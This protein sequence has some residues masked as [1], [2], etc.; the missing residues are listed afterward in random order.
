MPSQ[1]SSDEFYSESTRAALA[2]VIPGFEEE[3]SQLDRID[4]CLMDVADFVDEVGRQHLSPEIIAI[5]S[6][7]WNTRNQLAEI[8]ADPATDIDVLVN[9]AMET[10]GAAVELRVWLTGTGVDMAGGERFRT[11]QLKGRK[12]AALVKKSD[13]QAQ[14][15][16][17]Q[18]E[19]ERLRASNPALSKNGAAQIISRRTGTPQRTIRKYLS[20]EL[21]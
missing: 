15:K 11:W 12:S 1:Q 20:D 13:A 6:R 18:S 19:Y 4:F 5:F 21:P 3:G 10:Y 8:A 16:K 17:W 14:R 7:A 9:L 2:R